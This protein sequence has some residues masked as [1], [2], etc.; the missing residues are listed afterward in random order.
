MHGQHGSD[1]ALDVLADVRATLDNAV[2]RCFLGRVHR[3]VGCEHVLEAVPV[4]GVHAPEVP[5]FELLDLFDRV[6]LFERV[7][8]L[9]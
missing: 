9:R 2:L 4:L 7:H 3:R 6:E 1:H 5:G 8:L